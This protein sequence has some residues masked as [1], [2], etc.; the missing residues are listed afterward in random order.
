MG[1]ELLH[2]PT[3]LPKQEPGKMASFLVKVRLL[4][5][6]AQLLRVT[7]KLDSSLGK[8]PSPTKMD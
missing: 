2:G 4:T 3:A 6:M 1:R 5:R 7:G 8:E